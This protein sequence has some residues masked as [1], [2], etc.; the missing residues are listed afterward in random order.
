[1]EFVKVSTEQRLFRVQRHPWKA[2]LVSGWH[3]RLKNFLL[4]LLF[5]VVLSGC[6]PGSTRTRLTTTT[7]PSSRL[8]EPSLQQHQLKG[9]EALPGP[10]T[11]SVSTWLAFSR[12]C[13]ENGLGTPAI[14]SSR[15]LRLATLTGLG[16]VVVEGGKPY[17]LLG[18]T[19]VFLA[20]PP[21]VVNGELILNGLDLE[22]K[23]R[24]L[25]CS[26]LNPQ[27]I[28]TVVIDP[29]HGGRNHGATN[30][31]DG[32]LE[33]DLT[34]DWAYRLAELFVMRGYRVFLTRTNDQDVSI[35]ARVGYAN[36][37]AADLFIS[38]HFNSV[39]PDQGQAG[40]ETYCLTPQG[41]PS[42]L[43]RGFEDP[44]DSAYP[45]NAFD[46]WNLFWAFRIHRSLVTATGA[47]DRGV[48]YT[49]F[50][51]VLRGQRCPAVLIEGGYLSNPTE[52]RKISNPAYRQRLAAA[53]ADAI[54]Q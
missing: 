41:L 34:L 46:E 12:W 49:R 52:A 36:S 28:R 4:G 19:A 5:V 37:I 33:K 50:M 21:R 13:V 9:P 16:E 17:M 27:P 15:P 44:M 11:N 14:L 25:A 26:R 39:I 35:A 51:A 6:T 45:N 42:T 8:A 43:N 40:I 48:R 3:S 23:L 24:P 2:F 29:G 31:W 47:P 22:K 30:V 32:S 10:L 20:Y 54:N 1:M 38:L 18:G 53:I 7:I